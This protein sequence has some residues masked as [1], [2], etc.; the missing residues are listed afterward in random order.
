VDVIGRDLKYN[1]AVSKYWRASVRKVS[2][3]MHVLSYM[4]GEDLA[5]DT[6]VPSH[7]EVRAAPG[8]YY[9]MRMGKVGRCIFETWH[10]TLAEAK[11]QAEFEYA[12]NEADWAELAS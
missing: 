2:N 3:A 6:E 7:V 4:Q 5:R 12:I 11:A 1:V 8:G 10:M 9:L